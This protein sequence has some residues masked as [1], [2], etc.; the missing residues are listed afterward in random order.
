MKTIYRINTIIL[1][2][3]PIA[4]ANQWSEMLEEFRAKDKE[5]Y[6]NNKNQLRYDVILKNITE[7]L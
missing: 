5:T 2:S 6:I 3:I 1:L 7:S 4:G